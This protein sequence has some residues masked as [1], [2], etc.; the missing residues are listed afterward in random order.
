MVESSP[1][2]VVPSA[3]I[4]GLYAK[5]LSTPPTRRG[6]RARTRSQRRT[7]S[8]VCRIGNYVRTSDKTDEELLSERLKT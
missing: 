2:L 1:P 7:L 3:E 5:R 6:K 4:E 8:T